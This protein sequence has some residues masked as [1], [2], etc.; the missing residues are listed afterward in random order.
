[1]FINKAKASTRVEALKYLLPIDYF[2]KPWIIYLIMK[3]QKTPI[4]QIVQ[5]HKTKPRNI[6][7]VCK[8]NRNRSV[9][10]ERLFRGML[11]EKG[12]YVFDSQDKKTQ[13]DY[14]VRVSSAGMNPFTNEGKKLEFSMADEANLIFTFEEGLEYALIHYFFQ[15]REKVVNL[16]IPD[17][18]DIDN[19]SDEYNLRRI[20]RKKLSIYIPLP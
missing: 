8:A 5:E 18:Y 20:L 15:P 6:L 9:A 16:D 2:Y 1:M 14:D 11:K 10:G 13:R 4:E 12:Y 3:K 17:H 7:F 19:D